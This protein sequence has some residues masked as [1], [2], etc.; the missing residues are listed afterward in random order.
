MTVYTLTLAAGER[1]AFDWVGVRYATG[2]GVANILVDCLAPDDEW[3]QDGPITFQVPEHMAWEI[4]A[5]AAQEGD[6]WPC[7]DATLRTKMQE[8][9]DQIV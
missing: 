8:F 9:C 6:L 3:S 1:K 4:E 2:F 5:L 7:F